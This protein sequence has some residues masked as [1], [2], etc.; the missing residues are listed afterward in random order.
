M[1]AAGGTAQ[2][3]QTGAEETGTAE[4]TTATTVAATEFPNGTE[5]SGS[6]HVPY[7]EGEFLTLIFSIDNS[8]VSAPHLITPVDIANA[9]NELAV[10]R[11][12]PAITFY[13]ASSPAPLNWA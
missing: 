2:A 11:G 5:F 13:G 8:E 7:A 3:A 6:S 12:W 4:E 1:L 10:S 9:L